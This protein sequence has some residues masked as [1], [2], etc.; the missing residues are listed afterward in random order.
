L[1]PVAGETPFLAEVR[2]LLGPPPEEM[3]GTDDGF[4]PLE[5]RLGVSFPGDF[6][7][8]LGTYGPG[9]VSDD[10]MLYHPIISLP[11][12]YTLD[13]YITELFDQ[14]ELEPMYFAPDIDAPSFRMGAG[15][16][17]LLP[18][19]EALNWIGLY[20]IVSE[21]PDWEVL[22]YTQG[23]YERTGLGFGAWLL[24]YLRGGGSARDFVTPKPERMPYR[25]IAARPFS[26][27]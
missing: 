13:E 10:I 15:L 7:D 26:Q 8:F 14:V 16:G 6:K 23:E 24:R 5:E 21:D 4:E 18:F 22:E 3:A 17:E 11:G 19:G 2:D 25:F 1:Y 20:F 12:F 27:G 9:T